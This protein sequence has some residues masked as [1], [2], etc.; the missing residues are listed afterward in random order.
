MQHKVIIFFL[1]VTAATGCRNGNED[2]EIG[3]LAEKNLALAAEQY[4]AMAESLKG[5]DLLPRSIDPATGRLVTS[6]TDWWTSGFYPGSLW[7]L[8]EHS[9]DGDLLD[10][11]R[12]RTAMLSRE[13]FNK[14]T[15]DLGF[16]LNNSFG[17]GYRITGDSTYRQVLLTGAG[18]LASRY[19]DTVGCIKSWDG[20]TW[21]FPV[22]IDNMMNLELLFRAFRLSGD[23]SFYRIAVRHAN[24]TLRNHLRKDFSSWHVVDYDPS[25][26]QVLSRGTHQGAADSSTWARGE[27]WGL[28]GFTMAF[29]ETGDTAYLD[30][31]NGMASFILDNPNYPEDGIPYWD[32]DAPGIPDTYKD[33]SA[34]AIMCS[35]LLELQEYTGETRSRQ[36]RDAAYRII[37]TL[38]SGKYRASKGEQANFLIRHCVGSLPGQSEVDVPLTYADYYYIESLMRILGGGFN[39]DSNKQNR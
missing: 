17:Q 35:A 7:Y 5:T 11:A 19:N 27:A 21:E 12:L 15:H 25:T 30:V 31:A 28:Y 18:S 1:M 24:T 8:Y 33:A 37:R 36:Y 38:S 39:T 3:K 10:E 32:F 29:R 22:I 23:S 9:G 26:G 16:M 6:G 34:A 13:Q 4:K 2:S 14:G 20:N